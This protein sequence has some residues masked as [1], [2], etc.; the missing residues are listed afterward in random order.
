MS[1]LTVMLGYNKFQWVMDVAQVVGLVKKVDG[2]D[3]L[4]TRLRVIFVLFCSR[5]GL[6]FRKVISVY[7]FGLKGPCTLDF[8]KEVML[9]CLFWHVP[10]YF[11]PMHVSF[12]FCRHSVFVDVSSGRN[13]SNPTRPYSFHP[14]PTRQNISARTNPTTIFTFF[15]FLWK[16]IYAVRLSI[17]DEN[18]LRAD[19][20]AFLDVSSSFML[21]KKLLE[22]P[23]SLDVLSDE[24]PCLPRNG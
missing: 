23:E 8:Q 22:A 24:N 16:K 20:A 9:A 6:W 17:I 21:M 3:V 11:A 2:K 7:P 19:F 1:T 10:I 5:E 15:T 18:V 13:F 12:A 14:D 4:T